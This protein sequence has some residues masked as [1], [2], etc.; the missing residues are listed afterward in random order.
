M[1]TNHLTK[2]YEIVNIKRFVN[3]RDVPDTVL[4]I[5]PYRIVVYQI[6]KLLPLFVNLS[7]FL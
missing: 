4:Q 6:R 5:P 3:G 1:T 2:Y 7:S